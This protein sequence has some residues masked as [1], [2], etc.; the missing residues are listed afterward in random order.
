[1]NRVAV[2]RRE[3]LAQHS[4]VAVERGRV[5]GTGNWHCGGGAAYTA[6]ETRYVSLKLVAS[7]GH[8]GAAFVTAVASKV[9]RRR[10]DATETGRDLWVS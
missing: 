10:P 9:F 7:L 4:D 2:A 6:S 3:V 1:M 8:R 5:N